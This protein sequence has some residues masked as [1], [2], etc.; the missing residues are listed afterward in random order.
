MKIF[1]VLFPI[2]LLSFA[3]VAQ[4]SV[5]TDGSDADPSAMLDVM[6]TNKGLLIPRV[7]FA[8]R[9]VNPAHSLLI[10]QT[11]SVPG[12]Y[13]YNGSEWINM[14]I[15]QTVAKQDYEVTL[16][17]GGGSFMT[18]LIS[19]TQAQI[20]AMTTYK[21][22]TVYNSTTNCINYY[23]MNN[24][25]ETC[26]TCTPMPSQAVAGDDQAFLD[27]TIA[28]T[29]EANTPEQ[30]EGLWVVASGTGGSF[31]D[32]TKPT[33]QFTG[34]PCT[35]YTLV[36]TIYN[37]CGST[38]DS[39]DISFFATPT[40]A[41]AGNDT[42]VEGGDLTFV[43]AA[44]TPEVGNGRWSV[45]NGEVG[46]FANASDATT[47]FA[48]QPNPEVKYTLQWEVAT[49]C[50]TTYDDVTITFYPWQ[51]GSPFTDIRDGQTYETV[52][53]GVQCWMAENINIGT[54]INGSDNQTDNEEFE[55][56]CYNNDTSNCDT[57]GGLY[58]W[59]EMMHYTAT[60]GVQGICSEGWH[61]P[62]DAEWCILEQEVDTNIICRSTDY[63]GVNGGTKL[64]QGGVSGFEA[65][66]AGYRIARN[67]PFDSLNSS[68][69]FWSSSIGGAAFAWQRNL[70][71]SKDKVSRLL[72]DKGFFGFSVRCIWD[73]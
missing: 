51:C 33:S 22:L 63:R 46:T 21:G 37:S 29:L 32:P 68:T 72:S 9:P 50:D 55:K 43:L 64:K 67:E 18:G 65:L 23:Y 45:L 16:S 17:Q 57:Y 73:Y 40:I 26:G 4:V 61:L 12:F 28:T 19:Y 13:Y 10:Y 60:A 14:D 71:E 11:D 5:N 53:I 54:M 62:T 41:F 42:I 52:Q 47:L 20:D 39:V 58:Q 25:F 44:N 66:L 59:N 3:S 7:P 56:Y 30:G 70:L 6:S 48:G 35:D 49:R 27:N 38:T 31:D 36:W 34:E 24:W 2:L 1:V 8:R 69:A 15:L